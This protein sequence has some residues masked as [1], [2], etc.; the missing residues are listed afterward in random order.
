MKIKHIFLSVL[1]A[2]SG[3][4][5]TACDNYLDEVPEASISPEVYFTEATHI[6]ASADNLYSDILP[7]HGT[8]NTYGIYKDDATTDNQ[9]EVTAPNRFTS[10]LW[11]V[12][13]AE[14]SNWNF[15]KI[16]KIN[17]VLSNVLPNFG[18]KNAD[19]NDLSGNAN[20]INGDLNSIKHYIGELFFLRACGDFFR[21]I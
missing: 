7:S 10:T 12:D 9:I 18:D 5:F 21:R 16:Y 13:N 17:F 2:S 11:K 3:F 4:I 6:Q 20:T 15:D 1:I 19:G 14:T 8:G